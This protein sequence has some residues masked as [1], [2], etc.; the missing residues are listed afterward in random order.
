MRE[1]NW[2]EAIGEPLMLIKDVPDVLFP[3]CSTA[4]N[5]GGSIV[6]FDNNFV[7]GRIWSLQSEWSSQGQR[8]PTLCKKSLDG[9]KVDL[10]STSL[11][12]ME[13]M[14]Y[15]E[16]SGLTLVGPVGIRDDVKGTI[17]II[18]GAG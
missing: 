10:D 3:A 1:R 5:A 4:F 7:L 6:P 14:M 17:Q 13:G 12:D 15:A 16:L 2:E 9:L 8:V 18:R 11:N